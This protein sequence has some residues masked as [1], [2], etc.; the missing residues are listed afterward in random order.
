M[1]TAITTRRSRLRSAITKSITISLLN[2]V[3]LLPVH[4]AFNLDPTFNGSGKVTVSFPDS[5]TTYRSQAFRVF[6]QPNNRIL[7]VGSFSNISP[8]GQLPGVAWAGLTP[9]GALDSGFGSGGTHTDWR[10]DART[11]F[12][13]AL[14][15]ADGSTLRIAQVSRLPVGSSTVQTVRLTA[16]GGV[17]NVFASNVSIGPCCFGFFT[18]RPVQIAVRSDGKILALVTDEGGYFLYRLNSDGTRDTTFGANGVLRIG[19]NK[20]SPTNFIEMIAMN[21]GKILLVGHVPPFDS[22]TGSSEFFFARLTETGNWDKTF[23]RSGFVRVAFGSGL[24][25]TVRKAL[26]QADGNILLCGNVVSSDTD[27]WMAR[28]RPNGRR[29]TTFGSD[30]VVVNDFAPGATDIAN[31]IAISPD[32]KIRIAG[33]IGSETT[34]SF[35]VARFSATGAFEEQTSF[36]FTA[37]QNAGASDVTLQPDGKLLVVGYTQNPNMSITGSVFAVA[38]LTE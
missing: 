3:W 25:G 18:A 5:S 7:V 20:F 15:Y 11:N 35:L 8:D 27:V 34:P 6:L 9:S 13:D 30:G 36:S 12:T 38:R 14:M 22:P 37:G 29:D 24:T 10:S 32:G 31:S 21:D 17:D 28:F 23:G 19:F 2:F 1:E 16:N 33:E 4:A 26:L